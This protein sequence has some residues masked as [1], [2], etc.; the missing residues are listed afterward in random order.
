MRVDCN[1][2]T[3][4]PKVIFY[5]PIMTL[6]FISHLPV[7]SGSNHGFKLESGLDVLIK[8]LHCGQTVLHTGQAAMNIQKTKFIKSV[9]L[10]KRDI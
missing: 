6:L 3:E 9:H 10:L 8:L 7:C 5:Y 4:L 1:F 2:S